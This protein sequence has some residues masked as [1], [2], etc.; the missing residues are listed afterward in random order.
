MFTESKFSLINVDTAVAATPS[1]NARSESTPTTP[2][3]L[4]SSRSSNDE[5][6]LF[7]KPPSPILRALTPTT[8]ISSKTISPNYDSDT[9]PM[10]TWDGDTDKMSVQDFSAD[11]AKAFKHY[12][13]AGSDVDIWYRA[14]LAATRADMD[15]IDAALELQYPSDITVQPTAAEY[16]TELLKC[17]LTMEELGRTK[18]KVAEH[19][20]W[21]HHAWANKMLR[22]ATKAGVS[23]ATTYIEQVR[24]E[25]PKPLRTKIGKT[26][27]DWPAFIKAIWDVNTVE[28]ELDMKEWKEEKEQWDS[29]TKMLQQRPAPASPT[30][31]IRG[32]LANARIGAPAQ[33][34]V[35]WPPLAPG[36]NPFQAALKRVPAVYG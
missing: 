29:I 22:L 19:D 2:S 9:M 5:L 31:G 14:L 17:R 3:S 36:A 26:H 20:V 35:G 13:V 32:Q 10:D 25:L 18:T 30:A 34:P 15:L 7:E 1:P 6:P 4:S 8:R 23:A 16:I 12:L 21:V 28:L 24:V 11:K 27:A 33:D